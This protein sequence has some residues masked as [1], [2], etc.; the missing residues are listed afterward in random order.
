MKQHSLADTPLAKV[1]QALFDAIESAEDQAALK[2]LNS[3]TYDLQP[4]LDQELANGVGR[5]LN[6]WVGL[7]LD[8]PD[9][10]ARYGD[11]IKSDFP[12]VFSDN[13]GP[14]TPKA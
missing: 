8:A 4:V 1:V 11:G 9:M 7:K 2:V 14:S 13:D 3:I 10:G 12:E 5:L 6:L